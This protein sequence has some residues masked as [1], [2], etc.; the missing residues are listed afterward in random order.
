MRS[1]TCHIELFVFLVQSIGHHDET[2]LG[3]D[4]VRETGAHRG[5]VNASE[6]VSR[7]LG[8]VV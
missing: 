2:F 5:I 6:P 4:V 8:L 7:L 3:S 1:D